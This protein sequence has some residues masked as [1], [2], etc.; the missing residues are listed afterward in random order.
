MRPDRIVSL[1]EAWAKDGDLAKQV[2]D[3]VVTAGI[4]LEDTS[5]Y[6][7]AV[8]ELVTAYARSKIRKIDPL[9]V[10]KEMLEEVFFDG[11]TFGLAVAATPDSDWEL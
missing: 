8:E 3:D 9:I 5:G 7:S 4:D 10:T 6:E 2:Q 1:L 11:L